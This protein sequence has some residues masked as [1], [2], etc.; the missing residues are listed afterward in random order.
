MISQLF[1]SEIYI[2]I[3][4]RPFQINRD[5][6]LT[7]G[8]NPNYFS[9]GFGV[10]FSTPSEVFPGLNREGLLRPPSIVPPE[11]PNRS[12][13]VFAE[14]L[15]ML[16]GYPV[17]IRNE[18]HR[19]ELLRDC[20][21]FHF[22]GLEQ[23]LIPHE[24]SWNPTRKREE[25]VIRLADIRPSGVSFVPDTLESRAGGNGPAHVPGWINYARPFI[26]EQ[27]RE[28]IVEV[29]G[30]NCRVDWRLSRTQFTGLVN[31][32]ISALLQVITNKLGLPVAHEYPMGLKMIERMGNGSSSSEAASPGNTPISDDKVKVRIGPECYVTVDGEEFWD[33]DGITVLDIQDNSPADEPY[34]PVNRP[35]SE[36]GRSAASGNSPVVPGPWPSQHT[37][38]RHVSV[39]PISTAPSSYP[40]NKKRK[41]AECAEEIGG[42]WMVKRGQ[43]RLRIQPVQGGD[44]KLEAVLVGVKLEAFSGEY[45]RNTKRAFLV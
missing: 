28:L 8:N 36:A 32:R 4:A 15:H 35:S 23:K 45:G 30:E 34:G 22:K 10:F 42:E 38:N 6:F 43:W 24:I 21:Y 44:G 31:Q 16:R 37:I 20:R 40:A 25:I 33:R 26:D 11:V 12:A 18:E 13:D 2:S 27:P 7:P 19:N 14:L 39:K 1:E 17:R 29:Q 9:L 41:W 5:L 3:G